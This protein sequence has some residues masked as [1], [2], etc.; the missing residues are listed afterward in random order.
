MKHFFKY[1]KG[2]ININE[3]NLFLTKSGNWSEIELLLE[4]SSK[5]KSQNSKKKIRTYSFY[6]ML[7]S[8]SLLLFFNLNNGKSGKMMLPLGI[9]LLLLSAYNYIRAGSGNQYKI[10][11]SKINKMEYSFNSLKIY[12]MNLDG[13][14]DFEKIENI[15]EKGVQILKDLKLIK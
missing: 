6:A 9:V 15:E 12:F 4:K 8:F 7:L 3:E 10:P 14:E 1:E 11:L 2:F 5:S 13:K